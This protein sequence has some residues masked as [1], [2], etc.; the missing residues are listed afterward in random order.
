MSIF[1]SFSSILFFVVIIIFIKISGNDKAAFMILLPIVYS[2]V[3]SS[4]CLIDIFKDFKVGVDKKLYLDFF[5]ALLPTMYTCL[6][7]LLMRK[8]I[9]DSMS[10]LGFK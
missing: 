2:L 10:F 4:L 1:Y 8:G 9:V 7:I 3:I 6:I 5:I